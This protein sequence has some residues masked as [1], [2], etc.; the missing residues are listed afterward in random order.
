MNRLEL[1]CVY[2]NISFEDQ[3]TDTLESALKTL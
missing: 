2:L 3:C 1:E